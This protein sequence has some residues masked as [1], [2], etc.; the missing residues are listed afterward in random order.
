[1][2]KST[3]INSRYGL[4]TVLGTTVGNPKYADCLCDCG[5]RRAVNKGNLRSG[6]SNGC[7][8][9]RRHVVK[10]GQARRVARTRTYLRWKAMH[11]RCQP[12]AQDSRNYADRG[13]SVCPQWSSFA[14]F[15]ESVG[16]CPEGLTL[17][18]INNDK[19]YEPGNCRW[20]SRAVQ[21]RNSRRVLLAEIDSEEMILKD[22]ACR[23]GVTDTAVH[24]EM[25]R[26]NI[27]AQAA[28]DAVKARRLNRQV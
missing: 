2:E 18:R 11:A 6:T 27:N 4:W 21:R 19:G 9:N 24:Q 22:A 23:I 7:G 12:D 26:K 14:A 20:A 17:D 25:K 8:C 5:T 13:I 28:L 10:H 3:D 15:F 16:E 1:M